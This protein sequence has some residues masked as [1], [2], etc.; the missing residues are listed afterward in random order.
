MTD[1]P[2]KP[3]SDPDVRRAVGAT[4]DHYRQHAERFRD[5]TWC[6]DVSQNI[7][8]LLRHI[9]AQAP[10]RILDLGCGPGRDLLEFTRR[11]HHAVGVDGC[12]EFVVM[13]KEASGCE[14]WQQDFLDLQLPESTFDGV[15]ANASLFHVP[16]RFMPDVLRRLFIA[17]K[18]GGVFCSSNPR[19][20]N[21]E[22]WSGDRYGIW[23]DESRWREVVQ[24]AGFV[25]LDCYYR[26]QGLPREQQPWLVTVWRK[27]ES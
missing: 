6:H 4:L 2:V 13:A 1:R 26:P 16:G 20:Q 27:P 24:R 7:D 8:A 23:Y 3:L 18:P 10:F 15:F 17:M 11:G 21:Q 22:G 25:E 12:A 9:T 19:G 14:V 5:G